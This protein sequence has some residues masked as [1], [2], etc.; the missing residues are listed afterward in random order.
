MAIT[1]PTEPVPA[2]RELTGTNILIMGD[3]GIGKSGLLA[4]T[5][6]LLGDPEDK[7]RAYPD[8]LRVPLLS[9]LD[10][11]DLRDKLAKVKPGSYPGIGL[12][13]LNVSY[14]H[15]LAWVMSN[16]KFNGVY[17]NHPSEN[18]QIA[19]PRVTHEF[20]TWLR[21][22]TFLG[23]HVVATCHVNIVEIRDKKGSLYNRWI[24]A[25][26]GGSPTSTYSAILKIFPI[27]GF[28]ALDEVL[29][30]PTR[31]VL[32]KPVADTRADASRI[33]EKEHELRRV[34][35]FE[36]NPNWLAN[37]KFA[38]FPPRVV[39]TEDWR[40]DWRLLQEAW[41]SGDTHLV[42]EEVVEAPGTKRAPSGMK[43]QM[44]RP[45]ALPKK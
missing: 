19:Y 27:V 21:E 38:G 26:T 11:L 15:A 36:Q 6:Y 41:G 42:S 12:D 1:L 20:T 2:D 40:D 31:T 25:F 33:E 10:H 3:Y 24:P 13:S 4:S 16:V 39:F 22:M 7:L 23:Y 14:D 35:H 44:G 17:L 32:G 43:P 5:G 18:P 8:L 28:M 34:V 45:H 37:N 9:W 30:P 29:K